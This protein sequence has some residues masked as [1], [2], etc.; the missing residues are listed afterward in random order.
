M[1]MAPSA[2]EDA[3]EDKTRGYLIPRGVRLVPHGP[4]APS[5]RV[6]PD[7]RPYLFPAITDKSGMAWSIHPD[8]PQPEAIRT[9]TVSTAKSAK[10]FKLSGYR[11]FQKWSVAYAAMEPEKARTPVDRWGNRDWR[12]P[13]H[14]TAYEIVT[15]LQEGAKEW[16]ALMENYRDQTLTRVREALHVLY[17]CVECVEIPYI[18]TGTQLRSIRQQQVKYQY[19]AKM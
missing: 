14:M 16:P 6:N 15:R 18:T 7:D 4:P 1:D 8:G 12:P 19:K 10:A 3:P 11:D 17:D 13:M 9:C 5:L 2:I